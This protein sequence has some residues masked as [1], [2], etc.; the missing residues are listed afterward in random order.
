MITVL[1]A[2]QPTWFTIDDSRFLLKPLSGLGKLNLLANQKTDVIR[3]SSDITT[4]SIA[5]CLIDWTDIIDD[6]GEQVKFP[7]GRSAVKV[8]DFATL[9]AIMSEIFNNAFS[10]DDSETKK[11]S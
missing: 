3:F 1:K 5:E 4:D 6:E 8:L 9:N 10:S 7:G 11:K 2:I